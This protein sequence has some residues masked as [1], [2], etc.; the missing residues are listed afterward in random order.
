ML[1]DDKLYAI[2]VFQ[3]S[4][5][6]VSNSMVSWYYEKFARVQGLKQIHT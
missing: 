6:N 3:V 4:G 1:Y 5:N 2:D